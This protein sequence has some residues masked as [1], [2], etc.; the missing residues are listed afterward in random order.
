MYYGLFFISLL[1]NVGLG[2]PGLIGRDTPSRGLR[3]PGS[4]SKFSIGGDIWTKSAGRGVDFDDDQ[5]DTGARDRGFESS[6]FLPKTDNNRGYPN[7]RQY[8]ENASRTNQLGYNSQSLTGGG[9]DGGSTLDISTPG[10]QSRWLQ[11]GG[12]DDRY[13]QAPDSR[14]IPSPFQGSNQF[15]IKGKMTPTGDY[16]QPPSLN[17]GSSGFGNRNEPIS[18][19]TAFDKLVRQKTC[20]RIN[21]YAVA[22]STYILH[23][24][25]A[26]HCFLHLFFTV[27]MV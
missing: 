14:A 4:T 15:S 27:A 10:G 21:I 12:R 19:P 24:E 16:F 5:I 18:M 3:T 25:L 26:Q 2:T 6:P 17:D 23:I 11:S 22:V 9:L 1:A 13:L 7:S 8:G 20:M